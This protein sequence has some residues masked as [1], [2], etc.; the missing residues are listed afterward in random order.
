[1]PTFVAARSQGCL[2]PSNLRMV[3]IVVYS[4]K[5]VSR[6]ISMPSP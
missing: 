4:F 3:T 5:R 6:S 1:M 2:A